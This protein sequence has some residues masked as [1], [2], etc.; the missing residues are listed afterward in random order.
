MAEEIIED[1]EVISA[2]QG[3]AAGSDLSIPGQVLPATIHILP[4]A[5]R[6]FLPVQ[7]LPIQMNEEYWLE[8]V[9]EIGEVAHH[10]VGLVMVDTDAIDTATFE[11]FIEMGSIARMHHPLKEDGKIQF[12]AEG[13]ERFRI[14]K[15]VSKK[16]PFMAQV[17]Y[18]A[19]P[20]EDAKEL[21]AY[22]N[23][24]IGIIK[25]L[26]PLNPLYG[27]ELKTHLERFNPSQPSS[28][29]DFGA[30]L[31]SAG[32][33]EL[34]DILRTVPLV[35][36]M[37]K[38]IA[39]LKQELEV[40]RLQSRI[41]NRVEGKIQEQQRRFF[42]RQQLKEIQK[43]L[44]ISKDDRTADMDKFH[45]R[46]QGL[47]VSSQAMK[48]IEEEMDKLS[49][50]ETGSPEY[51][52]TRNYL[53]WLTSIPWGRH[54]VDK[55]SLNHARRILNRDHEGLDDVKDRIIEF[56]SVGAL[57]GEVSGSI[58]LLVGPPG[59]GKTS[60][61]KSIA[62]ALGRKFYRF[63]VG[64]M[65]DEAEI[66]GHRR[67]YIGAMPGKFVQAIKST[68]V[69][70]PVIMLDEIDKIGVSFQGDPASA[71][72]EALDP[73]QNSEF[74]DHY[75]DVR[76]DLSRV[77]FV[78]TANQLDTIPGPLLD[79]ME[80]IQLSGYI[81]EEKEAI[82]KSHLWPKLLDRS[83]AGS[84][85]IKITDAAIRQ[86]IL[87][88]AREAGVRGLEKSLNKVIRKA[89]VQIV[90]KK[91]TP[92]RIGVKQLE[93][94]LGK[95][96]F[97]AERKMSGIGIVTGLAWTAMGGATLG[98]EATRV[99]E[100]QRGL[101]LTGQLGDVMKE[102]AEIAYSFVVA[103]RESFD[104]DGRYF[105]RAFIHLHVPEGATPKDG[106]SAGITMT[107]ALIS[108]A[109]NQRVR[110]PLA[111]TGELTLTGLVL[112]VGGIR[113]KLIAAR[114]SK[115]MEVILPEDNR[116]DVDELPKHIAQEMQIHFAGYYH[117]VINLVF[118]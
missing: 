41:R 102:S 110:R 73:E 21:R 54:S 27:E 16:R 87:G 22:G 38:V 66:K 8:T 24:I 88:Y 67:T 92:I 81:A 29:A 50:L 37:E 44:G 6:P 62:A 33:D 32:A 34:L 52:V 105:D 112:P 76:I 40:G 98:I 49:V 70:N 3:D 69:S 103:N 12:I 107:T 111:M 104:I 65:R 39:L 55:L 7:A 19:E 43:E 46:L 18:P 26:L 71:L 36:R 95:P 63:S 101:K 85:R 31:A 61:G 79:R 89:A 109:L 99:H 78:C 118:R 115:I 108:L 9:K 23:A 60:V 84:G 10:M 90:R 25:E 47:E 13:L 45:E 57:K 91:K 64:G 53:D 72:L 93:G 96:V 2:G 11:D 117:Q 56:I 5:D 35:R 59:V 106:P 30:I 17:E 97:R 116:R 77:L 42:L 74:L 80:I 1:G 100:K 48:V 51:A 75:L 58:I 83:G 28:L 68:A 4:V 20:E 114:R 94:Y 86:I 113:E 15:W 14:V 82:A